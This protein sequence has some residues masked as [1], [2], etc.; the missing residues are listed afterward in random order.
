MQRFYVD[1]AIKELDTGISVMHF[2]IDM[3]VRLPQ[4]CIV[5][6]ILVPLESFAT[7]PKLLEMKY[8]TVDSLKCFV[9]V[10]TRC[11]TH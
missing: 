6:T 5:S 9:P 7:T 4:T 11:P 1:I 3:G 2:C 10:F 8:S